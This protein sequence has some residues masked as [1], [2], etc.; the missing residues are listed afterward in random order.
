MNRQLIP[1]IVLLF[2]LTLDV[3]PAGAVAVPDQP[4]REFT[5]PVTRPHFTMRKN[6]AHFTM[7]D[8]RP[9]FTMPEED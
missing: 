1:S 8:S 5:M 2:G 7:P 4:G 6:K 3:F 9:H